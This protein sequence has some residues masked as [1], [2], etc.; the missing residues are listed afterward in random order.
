MKSILFRSI[1]VSLFVLTLSLFAFA[2]EG[3]MTTG[4]KTG[5]GGGSAPIS[6]SEGK[7][8]SNVDSNSNEDSAL[9]FLSWIEQV[10]ADVLN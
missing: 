4:S 8:D 5:T 9:D 10:F 6:T 3:D 7:T 2:D 1:G